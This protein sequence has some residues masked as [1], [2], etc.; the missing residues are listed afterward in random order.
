VGVEVLGADAGTTSS[1]RAAVPADLVLV[2]GVF[3][4]VTDADMMRT[5]DLLPT[6]CARRP[7]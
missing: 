2:C 6:L 5:I 1:Y 4:N 7:P 3:G